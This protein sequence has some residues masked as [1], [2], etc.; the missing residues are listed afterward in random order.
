MIFEEMMNRKEIDVGKE[1]LE[2]TE[3]KDESEK[4]E[5]LK[6]DI[7]YIERTSLATLMAQNGSTGEVKSLIVS[8]NVENNEEGLS[9]EEKNRIKEEHPDWPDE[10][11]D[12]ISSWEE[13]QI[14]DK[15]N[16]NVGYI[17]G[18][19]CLIRADINLN[20]KD[21]QG[22]TNQER[23]ENGLS[24]LDSNGR[25]I[26]L[27]HIGQRADS[28]LVELTYE[29]H[30]LDG[31]DSI[32]HDKNKESEVHGNG[33]NWNSQRKTHWESRSQQNQGGN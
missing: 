10:I 24:P 14:Y 15:A 27:H 4:L 20:Q 26:E 29:E 2:H 16:F 28:P 3:I 19:P 25:P 31:N 21:A 11:I 22:R 6:P 18:K 8:K 7:S 12:A 5:T 17:N 33:N 9:N 32:L 30:H 13:Y 23:M 1:S